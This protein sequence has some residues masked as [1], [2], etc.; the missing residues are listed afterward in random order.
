MTDKREPL[1]ALDELNQKYYTIFNEL[2][3]ARPALANCD[4]AFLSFVQNITEHYNAEAKLL[5]S[6]FL[7]VDEE[8]AKSWE[9]MEKLSDLFERFYFMGK[10]LK[11]NKDNLPE[12]LFALMNADIENEYQKLYYLFAG[13][14][15]PEMDRKIAEQKALHE[16]IV[17]NR[18]LWRRFL[19]FFKKPTQNYA[20]DLV[21]IEASEKAAKIFAKQEARIAELA[22]ERRRKLAEEAAN[23]SATRAEEWE[24]V[25]EQ[26]PAESGGKPQEAP[27]EPL[28]GDTKPVEGMTEDTPVKPPKKAKKRQKDKDKG[29]KK[30]AS[31]GNQ[32]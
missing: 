5:K 20:A 30:N 4:A 10:R 28:E 21:D 29:G 22:A 17:P 3:E 15:D 13:E 16:R 8:T 25:E 19:L 31:N 23:G 27:Q 18:N 9:R 26:E 12:G 11:A 2:K 32:T 1:N 14:Y 7:N 6:Q 24:I